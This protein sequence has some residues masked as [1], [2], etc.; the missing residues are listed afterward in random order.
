[1]FFDDGDLFMQYISTSDKGIFMLNDIFDVKM[2][3]QYKS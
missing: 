3:P 1:M 2:C